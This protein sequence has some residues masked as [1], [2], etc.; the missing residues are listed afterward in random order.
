MGGACTL[1]GCLV[2]VVIVVVVV[3]GIAVVVVTLSSN[4]SDRPS[5][6]TLNKSGGGFA[7]VLVGATGSFDPTQ[8]PVLVRTICCASAG[9]SPTAISSLPN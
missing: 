2:V 5:K 6:S 8:L 9:N 4:I 3:V 1:V 7:V